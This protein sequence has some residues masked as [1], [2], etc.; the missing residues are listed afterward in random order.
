MGGIIGFFQGRLVGGRTNLRNCENHGNILSTKTGKDDGA[1]AGGIVGRTNGLTTCGA[2]LWNC[3]NTGKV[4]YSDASFKN[5]Y[6]G[7]IAGSIYGE[8][9]NCYNGG[10]VGLAG[11]ETPEAALVTV[12]ALAGNLGNNKAHSSYYLVGSSVNPM[13]TSSK[14]KANDNVLSAAKDGTLSVS[15]KI[16]DKYYNNVVDA[17]NANRG[18]QTFY[19][20]WTTGPK[21]SLTGNVGIGD[22]LDLGNGGKL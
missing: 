17:L 20:N 15:I 1:Y 7:G 14:I 22:G 19:Y 12:G 4:Q 6:V 8:I 18:N 9:W 16:G 3:L 11:A 10:E 5:A 2:Y 21:F 13:G